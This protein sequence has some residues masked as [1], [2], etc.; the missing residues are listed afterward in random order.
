MYHFGADLITHVQSINLYLP[1]KNT[2]I[3]IGTQSNMVV[4]PDDWFL[5]EVA[6]SRPHKCCAIGQIFLDT[7]D[8]RH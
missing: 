7:P 2:G 4:L 8:L 5:Y 1:L 3:L 6:H